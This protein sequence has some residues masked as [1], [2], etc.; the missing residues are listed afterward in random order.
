MDL[1]ELHFTLP[2][3]TLLEFGLVFALDDACRSTRAVW[4]GDGTGFGRLQG[5]PPWPRRQCTSEACMR[6]RLSSR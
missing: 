6:Q 3:G 2:S 4:L 5:R 1:E